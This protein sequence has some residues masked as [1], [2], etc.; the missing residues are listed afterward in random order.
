MENENGLWGYINEDE[1]LVIDYEFD[2]GN[3]FTSA[4]TALVKNN[5]SWSTLILYKYNHE[6]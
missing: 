1:K 4:G 3:D 6:D 2:D 5:Y